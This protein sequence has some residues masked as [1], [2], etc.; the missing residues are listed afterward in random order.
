M[1]RINGTGRRYLNRFLKIKKMV[2]PTAVAYGTTY[3]GVR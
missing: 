1:Y 2:G 3:T